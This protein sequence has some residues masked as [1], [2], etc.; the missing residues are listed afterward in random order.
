MTGRQARRAVLLIG[1]FLLGFAQL[2]A[3]QT[4]QLTGRVSDA[5][6]AVVPGAA[7]TIVN[8]ATGM[9]REASTNDLGYYSVPLLP[10]GQYQVTVL[11][12]GFRPV[13]RSG[14]TL[15]VD[16]A[17]RVNFVLEV[18]DLAESIEVAADVAPIETE[19]SVLKEVVDERRI[20]ELP[21]NG[22]DATQLVLLLPGVYASNKDNGGLRQAGSGRGIVQA[23]I[24]S[25]GARS[26]MVNYALDGA[27][28]NDTYTNVALA[29]PNP[30]ALQEFS[31][32]TNNFSAEHGRSAGAIVNAVTRSGGNQFHGSV[33]EF[34]RN[35]AL[36]ARNF[37]ATGSDGLKRHQFGGTIGGP[38]LRDKLFF[39]FSHQET[40]ERST[41]S[42]LSQTV[43]TQAQRDGDFSAHSAPIID[44]LSGEAF[45]GNQIPI[46]RMNVVTRNVL[47][48]LIPLPTEAGSGLFRYSVPNNSNLRQSVLR[49]DY[50]ISS[51]DTLTGRYLYN[52][53]QQP[54]N[55]SD[56][57]FATRLDR[58]TPNHNLSLTHT[59]IFSPT[60]LNQ[61]QFS[62]NRRT[63]RGQ[64]VWTTS[65]VDLGMQNVFTD[66]PNPNFG[67]RVIGA[68][69]ASVTEKITTSPQQW[70]FSDT[71]RAT[72]GRHELSI[73]FEYRKQN[74]NKNFRWLL[75]PNVRFEGNFSGY[76]VSD[77]FLGDISRMDQMAFGEV[78]EQDFPAYAAFFQDNVR[79][80]PRF[81]L[82]VGLRF[83]P[84]IPYHDKGD[85]VSVFRPGTQSQVFVNAPEGLL[86]PGDPGVPQRGT[87]SDINNLAP[88]LGFAWAVTPKTSVRAA[89]GIFYDSSPMSAITNVFQGVAPFGTRLILRPPPGSF[90]D[91]YAGNNPFPLPFP[92]P[93]DVSF[94]DNLFAATYPE[95]FRSGYLQS[96]HLT[97]ER[98]IL[99]NWKVRAAYAGSK[100]TALLQGWDRNAAPYIPGASTTGNVSERRPF[101]PAF[102]AIEVVDSV[103]NSSFHSLQLSIDKRFSGGF[104]ILANYTW[105]KSIDYGSGGG[106]Q[107]PDYTNPFDFRHDRG[108]SDFDHRHRFVTSWLWELPRLASAQPLVKQVLGGW[109]LNGALTL[110]SG[111]LFSINSGQDNSLS[112]VGSDRADLVGDPTT[113]S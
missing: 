106:T 65:F 21:L 71:V 72:M 82:N 46:S 85:R 99:H 66:E 35:E 45:P 20:R 95:K 55:D 92:P 17:A 11:M 54:S 26:N 101:G 68:F 49:M 41:P 34:H 44:P 10:P 56:L 29:F 63:D 64:P 36:N 89:Y 28:H 6:G 18:G 104:T 42:D 77:F 94:P 15:E 7:V 33:F 52:Y 13:S 38:I 84:F 113:P 59:R 78:G 69:N 67:L 57:V 40:R 16:Q 8:K 90:D 61:L 43:L 51:K 37:F 87:K 1:L 9:R 109:D 74:L 107:W 31:V 76:G 98:E 80:T 97:I 24:S 73:G 75:D 112:G 100:G 58:S 12:D 47:D 81:T 5:T 39:F 88:R 19:S 70:G 14:I 91:P 32:Q 4:T 103:A 86:F 62:M 3:Q 108:P 96:W 22:R 30:D 105:A 60:V 79:L 50:Q 83:E 93:S 53:F 110:Q 111:D 2:S 102:D 48:Q 27:F 25:N 23:G